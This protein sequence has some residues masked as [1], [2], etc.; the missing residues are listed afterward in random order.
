MVGK[1]AYLRAPAPTPIPIPIPIPIAASIAVR[2]PASAPLPRTTST[3]ILKTTTTTRTTTTAAVLDDRELSPVCTAISSS[4]CDADDE[5]AMSSGDNNVPSRPLSVAIP[6]GPYYPRRPTLAEIL[7]NAAPPPWTLSAFM[8]FLS[9]NHCLETL[10]FTMDASRYQRQYDDVMSTGPTPAP[11]DAPAAA[12]EYVQMLWRRLLD[13]YI[14]PNGP[15]EVNLPGDVRDRLLSLTNN[16]DAR[17][18]SPRS[19]EPAVKII[20]DLMDESVLVPFLNSFS[21]SRTVPTSPLHFSLAQ[22]QSAA[23]SPTGSSR[24]APWAEPPDGGDVMIIDSDESRHSNRSRRVRGRQDP[25]PS[26][27][28][29]GGGGGGGG[30][31][32]G[33]GGAGG[34]GDAG[35]HSSSVSSSTGSRRR[36]RAA[37]QALT[38]G[39][40]QRSSAASG[41]STASGDNLTDD[42]ASPSSPGHEPMTP[43]TTPPT[44]DIG[45]GGGVS[46]RGRTDRTWHKMTDRLRWRKKSTPNLCEDVPPPPPHPHHRHQHS[47]E[48]DAGGQAGPS[49]SSGPPQL[50]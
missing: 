11:A 31:N 27:S 24:V 5:G 46:P 25:S 19:L 28:A 8:A 21:G 22:S 39:M 42:S 29:D 4:D 40:G 10:E 18:P 34:G 9:Q 35:G 16:D 45:V 41:A 2:A 3:R 38:L 30:G 26:P 36:A 7:S 20:Y 17:P 37:R 50:S 6:D 14:V 49:G 32:T 43:P 48:D 44:S 23:N 33:G 15:R 13:A 1:R 47:V 12:C